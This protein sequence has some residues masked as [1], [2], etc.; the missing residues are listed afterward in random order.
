MFAISRITWDK[1]EEKWG[2]G[3]AARTGHG[4][5][6]NVET[7]QFNQPP[8]RPRRRKQLGKRRHDLGALPGR[9]AGKVHHHGAFARPEPARGH[10]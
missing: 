10:V 2:G 8:I 5:G 9:E 1:E 3:H 7:R 6:L 4:R